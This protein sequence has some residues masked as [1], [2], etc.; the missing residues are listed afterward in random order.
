[1]FLLDCH[2]HTTNSFDGNTPLFTMCDAANEQGFSVYTIA[3]HYECGFLDKRGGVEVIGNCYQ[4]IEAYKQSHKGG[5]KILKGIELGQML[6]KPDEVKMVMDAY[7]DQMDFV[8]GSLHNIKGEDD[9]YSMDYSALGTAR[10][11]ELTERYY[12]ELYEMSKVGG[13]DSM[14]HI[15]YPYR[16]AVIRNVPLDILRYDDMIAAMMKN[17]IE[18]GIA[19]EINTSG[20]RQGLGE[21]LPGVHQLKIY[22]DLGG[23]MLTIGSDAHRISDFGKHIADGLALA[24]EMGFSYITYFEKRKP[25]MVKL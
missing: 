7:G 17:L 1:M 16:Y 20:F 22:K 10:L 13:F 11:Q 15:T 23:E 2:N 9:F 21:P 19:L 3:E 24:K 6:H 12:A 5:T 14:A 8:I 25:V 4:E 18:K